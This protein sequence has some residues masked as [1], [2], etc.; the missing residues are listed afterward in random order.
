MHAASI[1]S[2]ALFYTLSGVSATLGATQ[3]LTEVNGAYLLG[4]HVDE[5]DTIAVRRRYST[6]AVV[7]RRLTD[8]ARRAVL[9]SA[10]K[11]APSCSTMKSAINRT[12]HALVIHEHRPQQMHLRIDD[13]PAVSSKRVFGTALAALSAALAVAQRLFQSELCPTP[14]D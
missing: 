3:F 7:L 10:T 12:L 2:D 1:K 8:G 14:P 13:G 5:Q 6:T 9:T 4:F 11:R